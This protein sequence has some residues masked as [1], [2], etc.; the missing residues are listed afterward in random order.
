MREARIIKAENGYVIDL[1]DCHSK[2]TYVF[3]DLNSALKCAADHIE[4]ED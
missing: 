4:K 1:W 2:V 3:V